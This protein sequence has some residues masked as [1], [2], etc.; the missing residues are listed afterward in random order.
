LETSIILDLKLRTVSVLK[1]WHLFQMVKVF[2]VLK[3]V[4]WSQPYDRELQRQRC[5]NLQ[6]C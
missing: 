2:G 6:R 5:K 1:N 3:T 4:A